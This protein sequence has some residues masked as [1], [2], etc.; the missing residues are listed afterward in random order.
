M[1]SM[2]HACLMLEKDAIVCL[3]KTIDSTRTKLYE[4]Y[5][6][7]QNERNRLHLPESINI[8]IQF[9]FSSVCPV[10]IM[11][12]LF[13]Q[14]DPFQPTKDLQSHFQKPA[15]TEFGALPQLPVASRLES[16]SNSLASM[17]K[18]KHPSHAPSHC[19]KRNSE[20]VDRN[21]TYINEAANLT[22][23]L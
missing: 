14:T 2:A 5:R 8:S 15:R 19:L 6:I 12:I 9:N 1:T 11:F 7:F 21:I 22:Q 16:L 13:F 18:I 23:V 3:W 4:G 10:P 20:F 17:T